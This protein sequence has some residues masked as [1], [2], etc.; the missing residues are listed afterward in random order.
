[1]D[2]LRHTTTTLPDR[3]T[4]FIEDYW[5]TDGDTDLEESWT[6]HTRFNIIN[7]LPKF[8][9]TYVDG[10]L[11]KIQT[12]TRPGNVTVQ[13][14]TG[15]TKKDKEA[16]IAK[17]RVLEPKHKAAREKHFKEQG[18]SSYIKEEDRQEW[19]TLKDAAVRQYSLPPAP[20][21]PCIAVQLLC[22]AI[23][24]S[25]A[26]VAGYEQDNHVD[27][28]APLHSESFALIHKA[29]DI[30]QA[31]QIEGAAEAVNREWKKL[32]EPEPINGKKRPAAW[33]VTQVKSK[34]EIAQKARETGIEVH[35]G[36]IMA[37][38]HLKNAELE[39]KIQAWKGR[40]VYRG[41]LT[42]TEKGTY[43]VFTE[44]GTSA[45]SMTATKFLDAI[46]RTV[47]CEGWDA[48][49]SSAFTQITLEE[50]AIL[51]GIDHVPKTWISLPK[52]RWPD[53]WWD[54][55]DDYEPVCPLVTNLYGH[56]LAGLLWDKC[57]QELIMKCGFQKVPSWESLYVH[58]A[59][60]IF[61]SV[62]VDDFHMAG[63]ATYMKQT[64][65]E[66]GKEIA[67]GD[68]TPFSGTTYLGCTQEDIA[69]PD[70][71]VTSK[72][73]TFASF[74]GDEKHISAQDFEIIPLTKQDKA[75][76][77]FEKKKIKAKAKAKGRTTTKTKNMALLAAEISGNVRG[78][79]YRMEGA[80]M[81]CT[82]RYLE[83]SGKTL[84]QL[85]PAA[86]PCIDDHMLAPEDFTS[87][88]A[89]TANASKAVLKYLYMTRLA[90]PELYW[91]VNT[92]A[93]EVTK[94]NK[95][96]DKRMERLASYV[97]HHRNDVLVSFIG[98]KVSDC[99]LVLFCDAS[100][101]GDL[102]DSKSTSGSLIALIGPN[103]FCPL[104][105]QCKKQGAVSHSSTEAEIIALDMGLRLDG[106][107]C[108]ALW[109]LAVQVL[110]PNAA[111]KSAKAR[112]LPS[113]PK[114]VL[115]LLGVDYMP[116]SV[117]PA[118]GFARLIILEDN[119]AV[120]KMVMKGRSP[121]MT[122]VAR[123]HRVDLDW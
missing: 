113:L 77:K 90:R 100:F 80:S 120:I 40:V 53:S 51:L 36:E 66:L 94:W 103:T 6:G 78:W 95:A 64:Q 91:A 68:W 13:M 73:E 70:S 56:P 84:K 60:G 46:A 86:T 29:V 122:H 58:K 112:K 1:M 99:R 104:Q 37:L 101:A 57:S 54:F 88:G 43:A 108:L 18:L 49:A 27:H 31:M 121:A 44:Q 24:S 85:K 12:T 107:R 33:D 52:D 114:D 47:D 42:K 26:K 48:D 15:M 21:M 20:Q 59:R 3:K 2:V 65:K 34:H 123:T 67:F 116:D 87:K 79:Q 30:R 14:W 105:W 32:E 41:D 25:D 71:L 98:D 106:L 45:S 50:A 22:K 55:P 23:D 28:I 63:K 83:L 118:Q 10:V 92:L 62:Y 117:T 102:K 74:M 7:P 97:Y 115:T 11:T 5:V 81:A 17:W 76:I 119:D 111:P 4:R 39:E 38:C 16:A 35:F 82:E 109:D 9:F 61:L 8:G 75:K 89:L 110:E 93:R 69:I 96:C 72:R 19:Q